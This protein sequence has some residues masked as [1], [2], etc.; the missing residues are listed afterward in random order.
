M[1]NLDF[2]LGTAMERCGHA[3]SDVLLR[4]ARL[5]LRASVRERERVRVSALRWCSGADNLSGPHGTRWRVRQWFTRPERCSSQAAEP[6][7]QLSTLRQCTQEQLPASGSRLG[8]AC[9]GRARSFPY[10]IAQHQPLRQA[11]LATC[12]LRSACR[13][14]RIRKLRPLPHQTTSSPWGVLGREP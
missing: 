4:M 8:W 1:L 11:P 9:V 14:W 6:L 13:G 12:L 3:F 2:L 5:W 10:E 7:S